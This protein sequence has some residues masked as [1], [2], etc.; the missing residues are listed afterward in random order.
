MT[1]A[2]LPT[3]F[4]PIESSS[5]IRLG[6]KNDGG[7]VVS[8]H[9]VLRTDILIG[10]GLND[11]WSFEEQFSALNPKQVIGYDASVG[12]GPFIRKAVKSLCPWFPGTPWHY[13]KTIFRFRRFFSGLNQHFGL[14][15]GLSRDGFITMDE[16]IK[17]H[18]DGLIFLKIDI[19]GSEYRILDS[20]LR[21]QER[22]SG[23]VIEFHDLD[24]HIERVVD[25]VRRLSLKI[26]SVHA[27]NF[28]GVSA[29]G[30]LPLVVE[31]T[32]SSSEVLKGKPKTRLHQPNDSSQP[33]I[34]I[35]YSA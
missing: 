13:L 22:L 3:V 20:I 34:K 7:Y 11:D 30:G 9:D 16:V 18:P 21:N 17:R 2:S 23:L 15:V 26:V 5:L 32:F 29:P 31:I 24:I 19:E 4:K 33:D 27:N 10:L 6:R 35:L 12:T 28:A 25:F 14:H 1:S 8:E